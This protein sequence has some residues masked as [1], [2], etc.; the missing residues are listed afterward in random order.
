MVGRISSSICCIVFS[1]PI[2]IYENGLETN[3]FP[4]TFIGRHWSFW[5]LLVLVP[6]PRTHACHKTTKIIITQFDCG[7]SA[8]QQTSNNELIWS[9]HS[10]NFSGEIMINYRRKT[11][12]I[13]FYYYHTPIG[14]MDALT[15]AAQ[16]LMV[17]NEKLPISSQ[18]N[19][20]VRNSRCSF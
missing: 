20:A 6:V 9:S 16:H 15:V 12:R 1:V 13:Y 11:I 19:R 18:F 4:V 8:Q 3:I 14:V 5:C 2:H 10:L 7:T 17:T